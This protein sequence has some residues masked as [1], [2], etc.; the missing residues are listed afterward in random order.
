V[1]RVRPTPGSQLAL[2]CEY[3]Y[4]SW[5]SLPPA[6]AVKGIQVV[7]KVPDPASLPTL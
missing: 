5:S 7:T 4:H 2:F 1:R 3:D 6:S